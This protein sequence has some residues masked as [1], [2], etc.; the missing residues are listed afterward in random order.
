MAASENT[1]GSALTD[2]AGYNIYYGSSTAAMTTKISIKTVGVQDYVISELA[3]GN[4]YFAL[5]A[6]NSAG[7]ESVAS[8]TVETTL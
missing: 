6:V 1:D 3:S 8:N 4:W 2:L 7:M 5:T